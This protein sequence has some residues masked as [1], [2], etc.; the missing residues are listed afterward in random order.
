MAGFL[1]I[2]AP[3]KS[4]GFMSA[5]FDSMEVDAKEDMSSLLADIQA[6][7]RYGLV[8]V[9]ERFLNKVSENVMKRIK[10]KGLPIIMHINVPERWEEKW[11][12]ESPVVRLIR[13]AIGYQIKIKR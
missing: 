3:G 7:G 6:E 13:K 10:K 1:V 11:T 2:T 5:G 12:G 4:A 9:E 8:A